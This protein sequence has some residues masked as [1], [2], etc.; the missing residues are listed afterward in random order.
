MDRVT[1]DEIIRQAESWVGTPWIHGQALKR[2]G[3]D[4]V[5]LV[6]QTGKELG[7]VPQN[8]KPPGYNQDWAL[9]NEVS[10][11]EKEVAKFASKASEPFAVGDVILFVYG[12][13]ASHAG[14][15]IGKGNMIHA[16]QRRGVIKS[17][18]RHYMNKFHSVWR[19]NNG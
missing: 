10:V 8:Y 5:G 9:H 17:P 14:F 6:I 12:K 13:C 15:Y 18:V 16:Y 7:W 2:V 19:V 1:E 3:T 4:C 11:L